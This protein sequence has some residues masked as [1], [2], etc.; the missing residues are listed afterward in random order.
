MALQM[1]TEYSSEEELGFLEAG[2]GHARGSARSCGSPRILGVFTGALALV[3]CVIVT[4]S[5]SSQPE[6]RMTA[7]SLLDSQVLKDAATE[8][9]L[10]T[11][12]RGSH[13]LPRSFVQGAVADAFHNIS[14]RVQKTPK[15][16]R[17]LEQMEVRPELVEAM[18]LAMRN[19][20]DPRVQAIGRE[21]AEATLEGSQDGAG[22]AEGVKRHLLARFQSRVPEL[23]KLRDELIP[24][25]LRTKSTG[26]MTLDPEK[27]RVITTYSDT[28]DNWLP[29]TG[30]RRLAEGEVA[31]PDYDI[32]QMEDE[33]RPI[34]E[35]ME[36]PCKNGR[37]DNSVRGG[38]MSADDVKC[39]RQRFEQGLGVLAALCEQAR[40]ALN[41]IDFSSESFGKDLH[42]PFW[43][44]S[45]VGGLAFASE[46]GD[47]VMRAG[48]N[49]VKMMMC[50]AKYASAFTDLLAGLVRMAEKMESTGPPSMV[51]PAPAAVQPSGQAEGANKVYYNDW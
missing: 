18:A 44:K 33:L 35:D 34:P 16:L 39:L 43:S 32:Q 15:L 24:E 36:D 7:R 26:P 1:A 25:V 23:E 14:L 30:G 47:C 20:A 31:S 27:M 4:A 29:K 48:K 38:E 40:V 51:Q 45:L 21:V 42:I 12:R 28:E 6:H 13:S 8:Q 41:A 10:A 17:R 50:P 2:A 37:D 5:W 9:L 22:G 49:E 3:A 19:M 46:L 11:S